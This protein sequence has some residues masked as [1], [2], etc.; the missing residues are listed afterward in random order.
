MTVEVGDGLEDSDVVVLDGGDD[1]AVADD[2]VVAVGDAAVVVDE[3]Q[4]VNAR[5]PTPP[6]SPTALKPC[7]TMM[8]VLTMHAGQC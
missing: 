6:A 3:L 4:P 7:F 5:T 8:A 1:V 2:V